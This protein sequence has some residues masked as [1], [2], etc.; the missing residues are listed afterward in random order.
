MTSCTPS[1]SRKK[2][3]WF[4]SHPTYRAR[5]AA[6]APLPRAGRN[7]TV[8]AFQLFENPEAMEQELTEYLTAYL[9]HLRQLRAQAAAQ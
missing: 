5:I 9:H 2:N 8:S 3:R 4:A 1:S 7:D 6:V